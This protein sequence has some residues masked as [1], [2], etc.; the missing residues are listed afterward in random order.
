MDSTLI[1]F[2]VS[3]TWRDARSLPEGRRNDHGR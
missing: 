1:V 3:L 2:T